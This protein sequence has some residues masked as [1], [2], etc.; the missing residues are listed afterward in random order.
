M[1][2]LKKF[3]IFILF[4]A[5]GGLLAQEAARV[6]NQDFSQGIIIELEAN[7]LAPSS[8]FLVVRDSSNHRLAI[9][10]LSLSNQNIP[11]KDTDEDSEI[12]NTAHWYYDAGSRLLLVDLRGIK[13][14]LAAGRT[15]QLT[16]L[17]QRIFENHL[18]LSVFETSASSGNLSD[19]LQKI[20][21]LVVDLK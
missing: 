16:I 10:N 15:L 8:N 5:S 3:L 6:A 11:I 9:S 13:S 4:L 18:S 17:P 1:A 20:S 14:L 7:V 12:E 21:D 2:M 19:E